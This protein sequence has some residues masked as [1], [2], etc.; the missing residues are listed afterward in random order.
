MGR[1]KLDK[2]ECDA[3]AVEHVTADVKEIVEAVSLLA[4][5]VADDIEMCILVGEL[6]AQAFGMV[7][8]LLAQLPQTDVPHDNEGFDDD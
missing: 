4:A 5:K 2:F 8:E 7:A 6:Q 1:I 3:D